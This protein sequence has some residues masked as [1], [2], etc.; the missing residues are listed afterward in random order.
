VQAK[1]ASIEKYD[2]VWAYAKK[3]ILHMLFATSTAAAMVCLRY[4]C[5]PAYAGIKRF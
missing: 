3:G 1:S 4:E 5:Q 2:A